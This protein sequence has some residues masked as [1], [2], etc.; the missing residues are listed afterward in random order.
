MHGKVE[1]VCLTVGHTW[2]TILFHHSE[3]LRLLA[4]ACRQSGSDMDCPKLNRET[5][6]QLG[7]A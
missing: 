1:K 5:C 6:M 3:L 4:T 2:Q 7:R